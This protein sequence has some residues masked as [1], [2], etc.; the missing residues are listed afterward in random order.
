MQLSPHC[1]SEVMGLLSDQEQEI[2]SNFRHP[3]KRIEWAANR[4]LLKFA[5]LLG[6]GDLS[7]QQ[8]IEVSWADVVNYRSR[9]QYREI[10]VL[11]E[12][13]CLD[14]P[15]MVFDRTHGTCHRRVS[16]SH[17]WPF[18]SVGIS[19]GDER[20]GVDIEEITVFSN[21]FRQFYFGS[22]REELARLKLRSGIDMN[23]LCTFLWTL[24]EAFLKTCPRGRVNIEDI[25]ISLRGIP[26]ALRGGP[27]YAAFQQE[28]VCIDIGWNGVWIEGTAKLISNSHIMGC[29]LL[30]SNDHVLAIKP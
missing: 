17:K 21:E 2:L 29:L 19:S 27:E 14:G 9:V 20:V 22:E 16:I 26:S 5:Y 15:P 23:R 7:S 24:K 18:V 11:K 6:Q 28:V 10:E 13:G 1:F 8:W 4:A 12:G 25:A 30:P 3:V